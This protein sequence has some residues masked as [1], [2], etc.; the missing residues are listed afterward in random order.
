MPQSQQTI[1]RNTHTT[2]MKL[3][4]AMEKV[5][6]LRAQGLTMNAI[7]QQLGVS[8][9]RVHQ[10]L[11]AREIQS[12]IES[13]WTN[14]APKRCLKIIESLKL[15]T[16]QEVAEAII[17]Q[18]ITPNMTKNFG[19]RSYFD[20]CEWAN[21]QPPSDLTYPKRYNAIIHS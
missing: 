20:L 2:S 3:E 16:K 8:R 21:V 6:E 17:L 4:Y 1:P 19:I 14:G 18:R 10:I 12:Q 15:T 11:H 7:G 9:Q 5:Q 13:K